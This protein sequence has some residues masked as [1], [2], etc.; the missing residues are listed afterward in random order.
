MTQEILITLITAFLGSATTILT[1]WIK[2]KNDN[3]KLLLV[4]ANENNKILT[5][6]SKND[7]MQTERLEYQSAQLQRLENRIKGVE[8]KVNNLQVTS[9]LI[10]NDVAENK[11]LH[12]YSRFYGDLATEIDDEH[13]SCIDE[14]GIKRRTPTYDELGAIKEA[15]KDVLFTVI[16]KNFNVANRRYINDLFDIKLNA[17]INNDYNDLKQSFISFSST[18]YNI[19]NKKENG[20]R[21]LA[22]T[23]KTKEFIQEV[24]SVYIGIKKEAI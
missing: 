24:Y 14:Y 15:I 9:S 18:I 1:F 17:I 16:K 10:Q 21:R 20:V 19:C 4:V 5:E 2:T 3:K 13:I 11:E 12:K 8:A 7:K 6:V 22:M 23:E